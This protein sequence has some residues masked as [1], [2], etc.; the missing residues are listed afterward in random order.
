VPAGQPVCGACLVAPPPQHAAV[1]AVD[2]VHPWDTLIAEFKFHAA[3]D[4]A[5]VLAGQ[6]GAAIERQAAPRPDL[7]VPAPLGPARLRERGFNQAWELARVLARRF[8]MRTDPH[9]LRRLVDT[10]H[11]AGLPRAQREANVRGTYGIDVRRRDALAQRHVAIVDDVFTTG[12]SAAEMVRTLRAGGASQVSVW[13][14]A[15]TPA[16]PLH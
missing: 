1:A 12:A 6:L 16:P 15:R 10:P 2:Y 7:I 11:Q 14:V 8:G 5:P 9:L 13:V 3:I 4:L